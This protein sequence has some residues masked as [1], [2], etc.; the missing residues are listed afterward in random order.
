MSLSVIDVLWPR[1][2]INGVDRSYMAALGIQST[3]RGAH[4]CLGQVVIGIIRG[5]EVQY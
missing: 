2:G 1:C 5:C 3:R 4:S